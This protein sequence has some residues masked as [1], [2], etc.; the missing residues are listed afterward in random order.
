VNTDTALFLAAPYHRPKTDH[1]PIL[2]SLTRSYSDSACNSPFQFSDRLVRLVL[3]RLVSSSSQ[4][5]VAKYPALRSSLLKKFPPGKTTRHGRSTTRHPSSLRVYA[6]PADSRSSKRTHTLR[7][8]QLVH[9]SPAVAPHFTVAVSRQ[10]G[11][12]TVS[13]RP[14]VDPRQ[15]GQVV[16]A[17]RQSPGSLP[18]ASRQLPGC[19]FRRGGHRVCPAARLVGVECRSC[20]LWPP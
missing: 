11:S 15:G 14:A 6:A 3:D 2:N 7:G 13:H 19:L 8:P 17:S 20:W 9:P 16:T 10:A 12:Q 18:V 4:T 5:A 1:P